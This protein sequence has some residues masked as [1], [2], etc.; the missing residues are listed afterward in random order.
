MPYYFVPGVQAAADSL[1]LDRRKT[2]CA[3]PLYLAPE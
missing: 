1:F 2:F 3:L